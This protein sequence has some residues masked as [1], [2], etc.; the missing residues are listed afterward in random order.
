MSTAYT[1]NGEEQNTEDLTPL[2]ASGQDTG[3][4]LKRCIDQL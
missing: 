4:P 1:T 3:L 2:Q